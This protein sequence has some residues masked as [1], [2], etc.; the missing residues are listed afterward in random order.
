MTI[1]YNVAASVA[2]TAQ[3]VDVTRLDPGFRVRVFPTGGDTILVET[4]TTP[5]AAE[6]PGSA[7]WINWTPGAVTAAAQEVFTGKLTAVRVSRTAGANTS[8]YE[9][10]G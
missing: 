4:S 5:N 1:N 3:V 10:A 6:V 7:R 2:G 9:I 8:Y